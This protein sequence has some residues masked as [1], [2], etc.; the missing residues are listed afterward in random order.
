MIKLFI[1]AGAAL[2]FSLSAKAVTFKVF[3]KQ[4]GSVKIPFVRNADPAYNNQEEKYYSLKADFSEVER[5][6][7]LNMTAFNSLKAADLRSMSLEEFNQLYAR[8]SSGPMPLG[9]YSGTI[10][11]AKPPVFQAVKKRI[12]KQIHVVKPI[13]DITSV[14]C[15]HDGEDCLFEFIWRG[16][17]FYDKNS[18]GQIEARTAT[19][20]IPFTTMTL[21]P[22]NTYCGQSQVDSR[23]ESIIS[24][25][26]FSD[27][28][29][30]YVQIRDDLITRRNLNISEEYRLLRP[31]LY[32]GK[33]FSN[34]IFLFNLVLEKKDAVN[35]TENVNACFDGT[36]TR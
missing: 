3:E 12:M 34:R 15:G 19:S 32:L 1:S 33:V 25:G 16:K 17:K 2:L 6:A 24:D 26:G 4:F 8:L 21:F 29:S 23:R 11:T 13:V 9:D 5:L 27:D 31:G 10:L 22:M 35:L 28:F 14:I 30:S 20:L 7:P 18:M 36:K